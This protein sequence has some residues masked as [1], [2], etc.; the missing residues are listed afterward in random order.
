[1]HDGDQFNEAGSVRCA[2]APRSMR[3][4]PPLEKPTYAPDDLCARLNFSMGPNDELPDEAN[5]SPSA[6]ALARL[7]R[8]QGHYMRALDYDDTNLR[9]LLG[10]AYALDRL[11]RTSEARR[12]LRRLIDAGLPH[13]SGPQS[14]WENHAV[15]SEAATH[16]AHLAHSRS[17]RRLVESLRVRLDA[18]QPMIYVT[19]IVAPLTDAPFEALINMSSEAAFDFAG[20]GDKR[21]Q[22]WLTADAAWLV[23][24]PNGR[25]HI[26]S[27]FD[28]IGARSWAVFWSDGFEALRSLDDDRDGEISGAELGGLALW[29]DANGNGVSD[30]GEVL[31]VTAH[32]IAGLAVRGDE[33][34]PGLLSAP[35]GVRLEDGR[36]RPLYD[37][38]PGL[39]PRVSLGEPVS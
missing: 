27:G 37:W 19:P 6:S 28:L 13:L 25:G 11:G 33:V 7:E 26:Q 1:L 35:G 24:D 30:A 36:T 17:D 2:A 20:T 29:R 34:R 8:A 39:A 10:H 32:G 5:A 22:G 31:P 12:E 16:L 14:D 23:W 9:A 3:D 18:S 4:G 38:T 21:A 15:L